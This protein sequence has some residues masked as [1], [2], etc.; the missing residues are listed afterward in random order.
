MPLRFKVAIAAILIAAFVIGAA[1]WTVLTRIDASTTSSSKQTA[2]LN[3]VVH[4]LQATDVQRSCESNSQRQAFATI[5]DLLADNFATPPYP[6]PARKEAVTG[7]RS[8][9]DLFRKPATTTC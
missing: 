2:S 7:L 1:V 4:Q 3:R 8:T 5:L 6:D 9:A